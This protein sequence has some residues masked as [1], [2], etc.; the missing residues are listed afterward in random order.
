MRLDFPIKLTKLSVLTPA[1]IQK[2][3]INNIIK[4][5]LDPWTVRNN[6]LKPV[7]RIRFY[8]VF[9]VY[10]YFLSENLFKA[11]GKLIGLAHP[12]Q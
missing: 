9:H 12:V 1:T 10:D 2:N 4:P 3:L 11:K 8:F 7:E 6:M 5:G